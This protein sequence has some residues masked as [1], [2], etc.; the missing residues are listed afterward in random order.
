MEVYHHKDRSLVRLK[1]NYET[2]LP[3]QYSVFAGNAKL[4]KELGLDITKANFQANM[5]FVQRK[6]IDSSYT[7]EFNDSEET[8]TSS[9]V[10]GSD[11]K[12]RSCLF[13]SCKSVCD[14][15]TKKR[16]NNKGLVKMSQQKRERMLVSSSVTANNYELDCKMKILSYIDYLAFKKCQMGLSAGLVIDKDEAF[17]KEVIARDGNTY[18]IY[19]VRA[20]FADKNILRSKLF[21]RTIKRRSRKYFFCKLRN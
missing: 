8:M 4:S 10:R 3:G 12:S 15:S 20:S 9:D 11:K 7:P 19:F 21:E 16:V 14:S 6:D 2:G 5:M 1:L 18:D 13:R 17:A